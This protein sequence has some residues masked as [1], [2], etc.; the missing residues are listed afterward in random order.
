MA[1]TDELKEYKEKRLA[2]RTEDHPLEY[3][4]FE[5]RIPLIRGAGV[6]SYPPAGGRA[7]CA[8]LAAANFGIPRHCR[9][10]RPVLAASRLAAQPL[11]RPAGHGWLPE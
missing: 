11:H 3:A 8:E 9:S 7:E 4:D 5:G 6:E 1:E 10:L 2:V